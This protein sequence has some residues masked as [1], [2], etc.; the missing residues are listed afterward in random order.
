VEH[1]TEDTKF[2]SVS[3]SERYK[4][5]SANMQWKVLFIT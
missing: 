5:F 3:C 1:F 2:L 4:I